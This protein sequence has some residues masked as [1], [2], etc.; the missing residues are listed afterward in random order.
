MET[1]SSQLK[2]MYMNWAPLWPMK[3]GHWTLSG[4]LFT[5]M[6]EV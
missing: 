1:E 6:E 4:W 2:R 3:L 5:S